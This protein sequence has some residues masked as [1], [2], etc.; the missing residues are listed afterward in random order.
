[1]TPATRDYHDI[2]GTYVFDGAHQRKGYWLNMFCKSLDV[3][4]HRDQFRA[5]PN[6]YLARF[7]LSDAQR[8]AVLMR[9]WLG[10]LRL[11]GNIYYTFKLAIAETRALFAASERNHLMQQL[12]LERERQAELIDG[13]SFAEGMRAFIERRP[14]VFRGRG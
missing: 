10:L 1:M 5:N 6:D 8:E 7:P 4:A 14:P 13:E 3:A 9:D 2:P 11:G 12:A